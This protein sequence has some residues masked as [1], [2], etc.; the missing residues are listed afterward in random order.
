MVNKDIEK[1]MPEICYGILPTTGELIIIKY[2][3]DGYFKDNS[4]IDPKKVNELNESIG[5][6]KRQRIAMEMGSMFGWDTPSANPNN[7]DE[8]GRWIRD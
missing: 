2:L 8:E 6:T 5:V 1:D 3:V 7:Y 4:G